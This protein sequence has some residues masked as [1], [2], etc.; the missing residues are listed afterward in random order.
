MWLTIGEH[1]YKKRGERQLRLFTRRASTSYVITAHR[2]KDV[3]EK[4]A[5]MYAGTHDTGRGIVRTVT[6]KVVEIQPD[7]ESVEIHQTAPR[8][9]QKNPR[10][11][12]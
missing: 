2:S 5:K 9:R 4:W 11:R 8:P 1:A 6:I 7:G 12:R 3:A 10:R